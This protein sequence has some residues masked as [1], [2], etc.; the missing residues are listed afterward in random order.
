LLGQKQRLTPQTK[1]GTL[2]AS[3]QRLLELMEGM[4]VPEDSEM[5][6]IIRDE[7]RLEI[8]Y[9]GKEVDGTTYYGF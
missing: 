8:S 3:I 1:P 4:D 5:L 2:E 6:Q 9:P 7:T